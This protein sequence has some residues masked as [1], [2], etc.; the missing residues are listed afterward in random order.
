MELIR[1]L[2][3]HHPLPSVYHIND[4]YLINDDNLTNNVNLTNDVN[5]TNECHITL[6]INSRSIEPINGPLTREI[7]AKEGKEPA[8]VLFLLFDLYR[9]L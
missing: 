2:K 4:I 8:E 9:R 1:P 5:L 6:A 3:S 7:L